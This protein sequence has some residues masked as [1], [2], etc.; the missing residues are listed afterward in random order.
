ML[1]DLLQL[2]LGD[3]HPRNIP[4]TEALRHQQE[5]SLKP[6][7]AWL[8]KFFEDGLLPSGVGV[9]APNRALSRS[10]PDVDG[11]NPRN[12]LYDLAREQPSLRHVDEQVLASHL[13]Q[14]GFI[15]WRNS[16]TRGWE[17]PPLSQC[18]ARWEEKY[19]GWKWQHPD[20]IEWQ[21]ADKTN[22]FAHPP[23]TY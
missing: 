7:D 4:A 5:R 1:H 16:Q 3:W 13:K 8:L 23:P 22:I 21:D 6:L 12:G 14:W 9:D 19:P 2:D 18:R 11:R 15:P 17:F 10:K 20:L